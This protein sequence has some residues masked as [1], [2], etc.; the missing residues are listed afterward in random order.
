MEVE[1]DIIED[2]YIPFLVRNV[3]KR[4]WDSFKESNMAETLFNEFLNAIKKDNLTDEFVELM[5]EFVKAAIFQVDKK[6]QEV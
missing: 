3:L 2:V 1:K 6:R 5:T 4:E